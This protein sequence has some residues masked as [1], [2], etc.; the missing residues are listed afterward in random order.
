MSVVKNQAMLDL[1]SPENIRLFVDSFYA[2]V[3]NDE[4]LEPFFTE[5][6]G[7]DLKV[8]IPTIC[9]YW[10]KLL[11]G[12]KSYQRHTMNIHRVVDNK[13][14]FTAQNFQ[15]WL[16]HFKCTAREFSGSKTDRAVTVASS[17]AANM[18]EAFERANDQRHAQNQLE[19][20]FP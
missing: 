4:T 2:K 3:L 17:I 12:D 10:E 7:I 19:G 5:V 14:R 16:S 20:H 1:D 13:Q 11:L 15:S 6:A 18:Q 9:S 8:H